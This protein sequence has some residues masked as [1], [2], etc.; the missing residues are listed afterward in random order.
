MVGHPFSASA[1]SLASRQETRSVTSHRGVGDDVGAA[2][3]ANGFLR[4]TR[5]QP[6][7]QLCAEVNIRRTTS[8]LFR[9]FSGQFLHFGA[10]SFSIYDRGSGDRY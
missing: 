5:P 1:F 10:I 6:A 7:E 8:G 4:H 9:D 2:K 3:D